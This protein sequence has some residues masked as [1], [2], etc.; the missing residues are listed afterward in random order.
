VIVAP[1]RGIIARPESETS[2]GI[3]GALMCLKE[4]GD[5]GVVPRGNHLPV[6]GREVGAEME[7]EAEAVEATAALAD[8]ESESRCTRSSEN[9]L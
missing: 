7:A 2:N 1:E 8:T 5:L 4:A 6:P 9:T 3:G